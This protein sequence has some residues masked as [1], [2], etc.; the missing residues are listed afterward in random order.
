MGSILNY[1]NWKRIYEQA[2]TGGDISNVKSKMAFVGATP[3]KTSNASALSQFQ[4]GISDAEITGDI[5]ETK[6]LFNKGQGQIKSSKFW[7]VKPKTQKA[8]NYLKI[9]DLMLNGDSGKPVTITVESANLLNMPIE[10]AGN[11]IFALGR[12]LVMRRE[13]KF[14]N[15]KIIIGLNT[16]TANSFEANV[17]TAFQNPIGGFRGTTLFTFVPSKAVIPG[18]GNTTHNVKVA[19]NMAEKGDLETAIS[20]TNKGAMPQVPKEYWEPLRKVAEIDTTGFVDKIK[21]KKIKEWTP[22]LTKYVDEYANTFF[23]PFVNAYAE[24]FKSYLEGEANK[25][26]IDSSLFSDLM[27]YI[28]EWKTKQSK[29]AYKNAVEKEIKSLF[30]IARTTGSTTKPVASTSTKVTKGTIGKIGQ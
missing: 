30:S 2:N 4:A 24:R 19:I 8:K 29:E 10:A 5:D 22:E 1:Y 20:A 14:F 11:G 13:N 23:E 9:G 28:D 12:A 18:A 6:A 3:D 7:E 17:D 27:N 21:E 25:A 15:G 16:K 26:G